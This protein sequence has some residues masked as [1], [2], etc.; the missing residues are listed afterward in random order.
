MCIHVCHFCSCFLNK[1]IG[2]YSGAICL[3]QHLFF[4]STTKS[5]IYSITRSTI[6]SNIKRWTL[7]IC[8]CATSRL[9]DIMIWAPS[10][11]VWRKKSQPKLGA[12]DSYI[13]SHLTNVWFYC[14]ISVLQLITTWCTPMVLTFALSCTKYNMW[15]IS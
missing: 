13:K 12:C 6:G 10:S 14:V 3:L 2:I 7:L 1:I 9:L 4:G 11:C 15:C 5:T 8:S